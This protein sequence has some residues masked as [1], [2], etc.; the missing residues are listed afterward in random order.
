[1]VRAAAHR[2]KPRP[3][4]RFGNWQDGKIV[5]FCHAGCTS[6]AIVSAMQLTPADLFSRPSMQRD[7]AARLAALLHRS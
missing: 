1:M 7:A 2:P 5:L 4:W 3:R 6:Q